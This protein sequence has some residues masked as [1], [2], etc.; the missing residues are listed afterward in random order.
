VPGG[1]YGVLH[2][3]WMRMYVYD[4]RGA[5][6]VFAERV[7]SDCSA[8]SLTVAK[9]KRPWPGGALI[10]GL[11]YMVEV[12]TM[13]PRWSSDSQEL[14]FLPLDAFCTECLGRAKPCLPLGT[15]RGAR[16]IGWYLSRRTARVQKAK[17]TRGLE[18]EVQ[19]QT[20]TGA[21]CLVPDL[22]A[23]CCGAWRQE[24]VLVRGIKM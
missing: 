17:A 12:T 15:R 9:K 10:D 18:L 11:R 2:V 5:D 6:G 24:V 21:Q 8:A 23:S 20:G 14:G 13:M 4:T 3:Y 1:R 22:I 7:G 16:I 19:T